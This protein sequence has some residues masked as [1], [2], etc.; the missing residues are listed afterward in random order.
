MR[1]AFLGVIWVL[2]AAAC[3]DNRVACLDDAERACGG[4]C[5]DTSF[6]NENCGGCGITCGAGEFCSDS[7]CTADAP[8]TLT[9]VS[10]SDWHGQLDPLVVNN[11]ETGGA[12][13]LS[14][15]FQNERAANP[16]TFIVTAG[17][18]VGATPPLS[19]FFNDEPAIKAMNL[20]G[21]GADTLGN[22]NFDG[23]LSRLHEHIDLADFKYVSSNLLNLS[24][25]LRGVASPYHIVTVG[26]VKVAIIGITNPDAPLLTS[27]GAMGSLAVSNPLD[28]AKAA[29]AAAEARG[30]RVFVVLAHMGATTFDGTNH[31]GPLIDLAA[32]LSGVHVIFGD[33]TDMLVNKTIN[34]NL[35][36]QNRSKGA[37]Y[38]RVTLTVVPSTGAIV[39]RTAE[40]V[41]PVASMVTPD[42][43]IV[44]MLAPYRAQLSASLDGKIAVANALF[45]RGANA[46]RLAEAAIGNLIANAIRTKYGTQL[47]LINGG[48][49]RAPLPSSYAPMD[50]TL[51]RTSPGYAPGP[52][53]DLVRGDIYTV[54]P[55]GNEV[56][57]RTVTGTQLYAMLENGVSQMP[58][59][60]GRF[61]QIDGFRFTY[62]VSA[63][64]GARVQSVTL[65]N[66]TP[67]MKDSTTYTLAT[68][69]FLNEGGD[70]YTVLADGQGTTRDVMADVVTAHITAAGTITP[71]VDGR[72]TQLP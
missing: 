21:V 13:V 24:S 39:A 5:V 49:I 17:D 71:M 31:G 29:M 10:I 65:A 46:E 9:F 42:P 47:A 7:V 44:S 32:G 51:R 19:G 15:Y 35:V 53:Y 20:M 55:F 45:P 38:G 25:N 60:N 34:D 16:N 28:S 26:N 54:L 8:V 2:V 27:V 68:V 61:P 40:I 56:V 1:R 18:A 6:D 4:V 69:D 66:G 50:T 72:I 22:H 43:A 48:G 3:G 67:V 70:G 59:A 57:T 41:D 14:A 36:V 23:G 63:A 37:T 64:V 33:H 62:S 52:P 30:A 11:V 12:A 58:A